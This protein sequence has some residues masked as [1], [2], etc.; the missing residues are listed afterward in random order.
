MQRDHVVSLSSKSSGSSAA[1]EL[2]KNP[3]FPAVLQ[4]FL[5]MNKAMQRA[6]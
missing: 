6:Q 4:A 2:L 1:F 5:L 3:K